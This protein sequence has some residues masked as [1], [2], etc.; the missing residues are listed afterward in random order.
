VKARMC[1]GLAVAVL[2]PVFLPNA[3]A[4]APAAP[5]P[6]ATS[7]CPVQFLNF[8]PGDTSVKVKNTTDKLV[9]GLVFNAAIADATE[10]WTWVH[11]DLDQNRSLRNFNWNRE[12]KPGASKRIIWWYTNLAFDHG[13]GAAMVLTSA[14]FADGSRWEAGQDLM[15]CGILWHNNHKKAFIQ[16]PDFP[17]LL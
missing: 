15:A 14:L 9:V 16:S 11:W 10:H 5:A 2:F 7:T 13:G 12:M 3:R 6:A 1:V 4:Q 17:P 8:D